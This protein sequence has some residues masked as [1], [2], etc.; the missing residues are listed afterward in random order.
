MPMASVGERVRSMQ[1]LNALTAHVED[2]Q[3]ALAQT[4]Q[5]LSQISNMVAAKMPASPQDSAIENRLNKIEQQVLQIQHAEPVTAASPVVTQETSTAVVADAT[6]EK[7][8]VKSSVSTHKRKVPPKPSH[9]THKV[10]SAKSTKTSSHWTLRAATPNEAWVSNGDSSDEFRH[11]Q[12]G[13]T[14]SGIGRIEA[15]RQT[16]DNWTIEGTQGSVR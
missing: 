2:L 4:T 7:P 5:Q 13:D 1:R 3:K 6:P 11:V 10:S 9:V 16:G 14:L 15:I 12:V 8:A